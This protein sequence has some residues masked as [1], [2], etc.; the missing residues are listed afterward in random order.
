MEPRQDSEIISFHFFQLFIE[1]FQFLIPVK[2][3]LA[4]LCRMMRAA[5][6]NQIDLNL[7]KEKEFYVG[8]NL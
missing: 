6:S 4:E 5:L 2:E 8:C 1:I 3:G 7:R